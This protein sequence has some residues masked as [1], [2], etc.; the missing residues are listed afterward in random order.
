MS[1]TRYERGET[2]G[3][4]IYVH[5]ISDVRFTGTAVKSFKTL[6]A[7]CGDKALQNVAI[8]T[9]MW[10][11]V[12]TEVGTAREE[13]LTSSF[14][15]PALDKGAQL[16]R[17]SDTIESA[18]DIIRTVLQH[19]QVA[20]QIQEEMIDHRKRV[21]DTAAGKELRRELDEQAGKRQ[22]QLQELQEMLSRTEAGD[23]ETRQEL[24]QEILKLREELAI[25]SRISG[26]SRMSNFR[27]V[28]KDLL[29]FTVVG[30]GCFLW[31]RTSSTEY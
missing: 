28:M 17:H 6:L 26:K 11:K 30:A 24:R 13:E 5:R 2:L 19:Q 8:M 4:I 12:T 9:N 21:S 23:E 29:F 18:H 16:L 1:I 27:E 31:V 15:K 10:G 3:G 22:I 20:L 25:L 14:F 7:M